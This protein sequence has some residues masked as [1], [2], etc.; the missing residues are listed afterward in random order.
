MRSRDSGSPDAR[1]RAANRSFAVSP[2]LTRASGANS[3]STTVGGSGASL[4]G[5]TIW[6]R[7][8]FSATG[9]RTGCCAFAPAHAD[10]ATPAAAVVGAGPCAA[11]R[12]LHWRESATRPSMANAA[13]A[14]AGRSNFFKDFPPT[15]AN[16]TC[17]PAKSARRLALR[18]TPL[19]H[20]LGILLDRHLDDSVRVPDHAET[21]GRNRGLRLSANRGD[22]GV[23]PRPH[24][25]E[26]HLEDAVLDLACGQRCAGLAGPV[27]Q[28]E[29]DLV[30]GDRSARSFPGAKPEL[31][32]LL[33]LEPLVG[34]EERHQ[35]HAAT[36]GLARRRRARHRRQ[37]QSQGGREGKSLR[38][39]R[40]W[41]F[42]TFSA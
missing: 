38:A 12:S 8:W 25:L 33:R 22:Q 2:I 28:R 36:V 30:A 29:R 11:P 4:G 39:A 9:T 35:R 18:V 32:G 31:V 40:H 23:L 34:V 24:R 41:F 1:S 37:H 6:M 27:T 21:D 19:P 16:A 10:P 20:H 13:R 5:G 26:R 14:T 42:H 15:T 17:D 7:P 3:G